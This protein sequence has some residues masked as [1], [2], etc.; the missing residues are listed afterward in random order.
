M[1][2]VIPLP[3]IAAFVLGIVSVGFVAALIATIRDL[4]LFPLM[5]P[6]TFLAVIFF[7]AFGPMAVSP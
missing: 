2:L 4:S 5:I 3:S 6:A 7:V 1:S